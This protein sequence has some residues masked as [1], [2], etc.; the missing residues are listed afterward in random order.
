MI[1]ELG[2]IPT[3]GVPEVFSHQLPLA[4]LTEACDFHLPSSVPIW[5]CEMMGFTAL[6]A[7]QPQLHTPKKGG[8]IELASYM[9]FGMPEEPPQVFHANP[10]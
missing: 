7:T 4:H 8:S 10:S 9:W 1:D 3:F 6:M 5:Q 2:S